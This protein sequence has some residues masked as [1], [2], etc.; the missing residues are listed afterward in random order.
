MEIVI[1]KNLHLFFAKI[2]TKKT[3]HLQKAECLQLKAISKFRIF[4][5]RRKPFAESGKQLWN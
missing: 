2:Y 1:N 3:F 5:N 4:A